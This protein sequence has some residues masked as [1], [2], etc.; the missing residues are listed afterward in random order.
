MSTRQW[1]CFAETRGLEVAA[2]LEI[3]GMCD[4]LQPSSLEHF[5]AL[6]WMLSKRFDL[7]KS[8]KM[9]DSDCIHGVM[10]AKEG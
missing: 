9:Q 10:I 2:F 6:L 4:D 8:N 1:R 5:S 7:S 3:V